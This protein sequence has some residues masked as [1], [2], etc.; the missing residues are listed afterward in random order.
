MNYHVLPCSM[1]WVISA[2]V[3]TALVSTSVSLLARQAPPATLALPA[4]S[5]AQDAQVDAHLLRVENAQLRAALARLQAELDTLRLSA[6]REALVEAL[7]RETDAPADATF[8]WQ[9][10]RF[11]LPSQEPKP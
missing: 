10:K 4:L 8:D 11:I 6:E 2:V 3:M 1:R 7:R 5:P 9:S